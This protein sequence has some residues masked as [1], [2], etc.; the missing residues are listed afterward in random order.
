MFLVRILSFH[1]FHMTG[2][3]EDAVEDCT[4]ERRERRQHKIQHD[5]TLVKNRCASPKT[6]RAAGI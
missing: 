5:W 1:F 2:E 3:H 4:V 6:Q